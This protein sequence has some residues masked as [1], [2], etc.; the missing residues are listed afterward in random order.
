MQHRA[1][2]LG[3]TSNDAAAQA[4]A[5]RPEL[6][7]ANA[8]DKDPLPAFLPAA[9]AKTLVT[10]LSAVRPGR[11]ATKQPWQEVRSRAAVALMLGG[12]ITPG[13]ARALELEDVIISG[14]R[15]KDTPWKL[16]VKGNGNAPARETPRAPW[17]GQL[18]RYWLDIRLEQRV[19]GTM[20]FPST[21]SSGKPWGKVAQY[22]AAKEV[23]SAAGL[24]DADGGS[25]R[26]RHT[27][28]LRQLRK[29][30]APQDVAK[31][32]GVTDPAV[33]ARY[34]RVIVAPIDVA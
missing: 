2:Q 4:L 10:Y 11:A 5:R 12:G 1:R 13:E 7:F 3:T 25:F 17:A 9:E 26:L 15:G 20:L 30:K 21:R 33:M 32:L 14:G 8:H 29:G 34:Q 28:A 24:E 27:F 23:L 31:W 16:Q 6:R 18:L 22:N 19:P